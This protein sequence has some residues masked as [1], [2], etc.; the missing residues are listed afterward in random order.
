[1]SKS[2]IRVKILQQD[3]VSTIKLL[4]SHPMETG[5]RI[6][7]A[8]G[9]RVP[10]HFIQEVVCEHN[11]KVVMSAQWGPAISKDPFLSFKLKG[12]RS[13]DRLKVRW[14]DNLGGNDAMETV[15]P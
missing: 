3:D 4:F 15:I 5:M 1:M 9:S 14:R 10:A 6:S 8:D 13:G 11:D 12:A 7:K 2:S